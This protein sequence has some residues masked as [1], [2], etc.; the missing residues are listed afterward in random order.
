MMRSGL[1]LL[2]IAALV[3]VE[4]TPGP[5]QRLAPNADLSSDTDRSGLVERNLG[6]MG[7][8]VTILVR[9]DD[10]PGA[11]AAIDAAIAEMMRLEAIMTDWDESSELM[12]VNREAYAVPVPVSAELFGCLQEGLEVGRMTD[13]AF[14]I[15]WRSAG[16]YW[17]FKADPP[18]LPDPSLVARAAELID[19]RQVILDPGARSVRLGKAHTQIGLGG[20]AKGWII[21]RA[22]DV[23]KARGFKHAVVNAGGDLMVSGRNTRDRLWWVAIRHP[24]Q[25]DQNLAVVPVA[26]LS[27][28]TSGDYERYL[29]I[30]G[31]RYCHIFDPRTG[32]PAS[33]CQSVTVLAANAARADA[34]AT[35]I[36]VL[37]PDQGLAL[38]ERL[39]GVEAMIVAADGTVRITSGL[40]RGSAAAA[41]D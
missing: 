5:N 22:M 13:G 2:L 1:M 27:I 3:A 9:S 40:Q 26:N 38:A 20:V 17:D 18:R 23:I 36:F 8:D 29:D 16:R 6:L 19:Y 15:T 30:D 25:P 39:D 34:L 31:K 14:D 4:T 41:G 10:G 7:T 12:R 33:G 21:D 11:N 32:W 24:R 28:V 37:G 35:G